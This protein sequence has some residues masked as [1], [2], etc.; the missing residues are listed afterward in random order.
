MIRDTSLRQRH[1]ARLRAAYVVGN[2]KISRMTSF[3]EAKSVGFN[4]SQI[5]VMD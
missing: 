4:S 1:P 5:S 3:K 2:W